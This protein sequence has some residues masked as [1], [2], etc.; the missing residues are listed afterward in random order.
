MSANFNRTDMDSNRMMFKK[1]YIEISNICNLSCSFCP[2]IKR[3]DKIMEPELLEK[4]IDQVSPLTSEVS[5]HLMGDPLMHPNLERIIDLC[6]TRNV[7]VNI[8]TNGV[9]LREAKFE[10]LLHSIVRQ[11]NFSLHSFLDNFPEGDPSKYLEKI[12]RFTDKALAERPD[13]YI[14]YRVWNL[15]DPRGAGER[16]KNILD[17]IESRFGVKIADN[18]DVRQKKNFHIMSRLY[19][20]FDT[21]FVWPDL[22]LPFRGTEGRCHGLS[23]HIGILADGS[24]V[25]CCLDKDGQITLGK[26]G[27]QKLVKILRGDRACAMKKGFGENRLVEDLCQRCQFI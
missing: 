6:A 13:L 18:Q 2:M 9:L 5:L 3:A 15:Q 23:S 19:L 17:K 20:H 10:I 25:P 4:I 27:D 22:S 12:F 7:R 8:V 21:E 11:I 26:L 14:N 16:N 24:V 1:V